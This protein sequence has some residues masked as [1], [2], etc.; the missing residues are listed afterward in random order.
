MRVLFKLTSVLTSGF[1]GIILALDSIIIYGNIAPVFR[2]F[3]ALSGA[4][5]LSSDAY[6]DIANKIYAIVGVVMLFVLAY[7]ILRAII[8]PDQSMKNDLGP[9]LVKRIII[10]VVG[11]ALAPVIFNVMYQGQNL[12]LEHD[13]LAKIFF[14]GNSNLVAHTGQS[15][16]QVGD[17]SVPI[18]SS[19]NIDEQ[20]KEIGGSV[21][22]VNLW[23][24]FFY[25]SEDSGKTADEIEA[26]PG[27]YFLSGTGYFLACAGIAVGAAALNIVPGL[28]TLASALVLGALVYTCG[29]GVSDYFTGSKVSGITNGDKVT[30]SEAY[31]Y[32]AGG[33][34]FGIFTVFLHNYVD[35][36]E[37]TYLFGLST[38]AG[39]FTLYAFISFS[40]DMGVRAAKLAYYQII[41]PVPLIMQV[42]PS[43]KSNFS[44]Y[45]KSVVSTF[46][47]VFIRIS[48]VYIVVYIICHLTE[49]FSSVEALWGNQNLSGIETML[50]LALLILG[51]VAFARQ[52]PKFIA[53]SL[54]IKTGDMK[55]GIGKKFAEGGGFAAKAI[56]ASGVRTAMQN[57]KKNKDQKGF[58]RVASTFAGGVSAAARSAYSQFG[59]GEGHKMA[60]TNE[61][62]K[63]IS[64]TSTEAAYQA[65]VDRDKRVEQ[66]GNDRKAEAKA[67]DALV[68]A[69][70]N[71]S[72]VLSN[73]NSTPEAIEAAKK[74]VEDAQD[75]LT[76]AR[77]RAFNSTGVGSVV[78]D[79]I[80][81]AT[82]WSTGTIDTTQYDKRAKLYGELAG[83]K[84]TLEG[85]V[86][87]DEAVQRAQQSVNEL[88]RRG[89]SEI[90]DMVYNN[91]LKK[92]AL[93]RTAR[94]NVTQ[95]AGE[96]DTQYE[97]RVQQ[98]INRLSSSNNTADLTAISH[99]M[100]TL[101]S[102]EFKRSD[103]VVDTKSQEYKDAVTELDDLRAAA[104]DE[105]K[106]VKKDAVAR[107]LI[108][109]SAGIDNDTSRALKA[110]FETHQQDLD[111]FRDVLFDGNQSLGDYITNNFGA[112]ALN[113]VID[114]S[115]MNRGIGNVNLELKNGLKVEVDTTSGDT[116]KY[117]IRN[118]DG[119]LFVD[120]TNAAHPI[121]YD[122]V[123]EEDFKKYVRDAKTEVKS[124]ATAPDAHGVVR[125]MESKASAMKTTAETAEQDFKDSDAYRSAKAQQRAQRENKGGRG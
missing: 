84:S 116:V 120:T 66:N 109:A 51:L 87:K 54:G 49:M 56:G 34:S 12:F 75:A 11:L 17:S 60:M 118:A 20:I 119:S 38:I 114:F 1:V 64:G 79:A 96:T 3:M 48:V 112:N 88:E 104:R 78:N 15:T 100:D 30:L 62:S 93:D 22:A 124:S 86:E 19:V 33:G 52:A 6:N 67:R 5:L 106:A 31:G 65:G 4:R 113:G 50:A 16:V 82:V 83:I 14:R 27:E 63:R 98:E 13:V 7:A 58:K 121:S 110:F 21:T 28:G 47:E 73:R 23:Q 36:G 42:L 46:M 77:A 41:A 55:L 103:Y 68:E 91:E 53:D 102:G 40:I 25:P 105:L 9:Q 43:F 117:T 97:H 108:E 123:S 70:R 92:R 80:K 18:E 111:S 44:Q 32:A 76:T 8:D 71:L 101:R 61:D 95:M 81:K 90:T 125:Y 72:T 122:G 59:P 2:I 69:E 35:D 39:A 115:A 57:W 10:A 107:K 37:I 24:A 94:N 26:D 29:S 89:V 85:T 74:A 45:L 99:E